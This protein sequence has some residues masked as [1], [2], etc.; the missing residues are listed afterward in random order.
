MSKT[1]FLLIGMVIAF[2]GM[3]LG[4][5]SIGTSGE[6]MVMMISW[7]LISIISIPPLVTIGD[8]DRQSNSLVD[9]AFLAFFA[10]LSGAVIVL[11][12]HKSPQT[13]V[14]ASSSLFICIWCVFAKFFIKNSVSMPPSEDKIRYLLSREGYSQED[15]DQIIKG[16]KL[17]NLI[18]TRG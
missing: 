2:A 12:S 7:G 13:T 16:F 17:D 10:I 11:L 6:D 3:V 14:V 5:I 18:Q 15:T 4:L 1:L 9:R 8:K